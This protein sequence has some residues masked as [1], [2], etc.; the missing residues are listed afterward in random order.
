MDNLYSDKIMEHFR[1][2]KNLGEIEDADG[3]GT[4]GNP[5]CGD[6][7]KMYIKIKNDKIA[8]IKFQT[9][10]CGAAIASS[11]IATELVKGKSLDEALKLSSREIAEQM[12]K[13]PPAKYHC[14]VLAE[15]GIK[16]AIEDYRSKKK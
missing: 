5:N 14:S 16:K 15:E 10:G 13:F 12:G 8:D 9:L 7:M 4:V 2:P 6:V 11:S 3:V 1:N